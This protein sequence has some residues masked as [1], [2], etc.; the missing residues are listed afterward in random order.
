MS[1]TVIYKLTEVFRDLQ[2][3]RMTHFSTKSLKAMNLLSHYFIG[4]LLTYKLYFSS[5]FSKNT[6]NKYYLTQVRSIY[7]IV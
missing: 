3:L 1:N 4:F 6:D 5:L 2:I 7:T